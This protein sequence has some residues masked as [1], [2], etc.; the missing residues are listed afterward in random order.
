[1][2]IFQ[3]TANP[4]SFAPPD[5]IHHNILDNAMPRVRLV[6][7]LF[8]MSVFSCA[9]A[10]PAKYDGAQNSRCH[11][12]VDDVSLRALVDQLVPLQLKRSKIA[13]AVVGIVCGKRTIVLHGYGF[14]DVASKQPV[15]AK[16]T[17]FRLGSLS[18]M[19]TSVAVMQLVEAKKLDLDR[20]VNAYLDFNIPTPPDGVPVTLR[21][22]LTHRAGFEEQFKGQVIAPGAAVPPLGRFLKDN[23]P[24]RL[25]PKGDVP[26]Y[27]NYGFALAG[28]IVERTSGEVFEQY[29]DTHIL[30]PLGLVNT[31]FAQPLA[32][33]LA[34]NLSRA[35]SDSGE[36]AQPE[37]HYQHAPAAGLSATGEDM[38]LLMQFFLD[39]PQL[40]ARHVLTQASYAQLLQPQEQAPPGMNR[41]LL[42]WMERSV[43]NVH[44]VGHSG[45]TLFFRSSLA[46]DP[47]NGLGIFVAYN[48]PGKGNIQESDALSLAVLENVFGPIAI[49]HARW[50]ANTTDLR[51]VVGSYQAG[52]RED[53]SFIKFLALL[54]QTKVSL[55]P[56]RT[57]VLEGSVKPDGSPRLWKEVGP[58]RFAATDAPK[59]IAFER[60]ADGTVRRLRYNSPGYV[61]LR[62]PFYLTKQF[63]FVTEGAAVVVVLLSLLEWPIAA[64]IRRRVKGIASRSRREAFERQSMRL[65]LLLTLVALLV[66]GLMNY[67]GSSNPAMFGPRLDPLLVVVYALGWLVCVGQAWVG[68][69]TLRFWMHGIGT[70]WDRIHFLLIWSALVVLTWAMLCWHV[71]GTTLSY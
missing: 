52:R 63:V 17:L 37:E 16:K 54:D 65:V 28:Y 30:R 64:L 38:T 1:L 57:I 21:R 36:P 12:K 51:D 53:S 55:G 70:L 67:L 50:V 59:L 27:S 23:L 35:Y 3:L 20:D 9:A 49:P 18:K 42:G 58:L 45:E 7:M 71:A 26:A 14:A 44:L 69:A 29:V 4:D 41:M 31:S 68:W 2:S 43:G 40:E 22:I 13:G 5:T 60:D 24:V 8:F 11:V 46:F 34:S 48:T 61:Y 39:P 47:D 15:D 66:T 19:L 33:R 6:L 56:N 10:E 25:F 62:V 32:P